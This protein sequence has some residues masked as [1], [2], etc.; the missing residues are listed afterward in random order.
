MQA[1]ARVQQADEDIGDLQNYISKIVIETLKRV[2]GTHELASGE[3]SY[4]DLGI[5]NQDIKQNAYR[6]QQQAPAT[7]RAPKEA[8]LDLIDFDKIIRQ[9]TNWPHFEPIFS[10]QMPDE[11][12]KKYYLAWLERLNE[13]RRVSAHKSPYRQY[14]DEDL[15]FVSFIK[16][17]L[18]ERFMKAGFDVA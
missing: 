13:I 6:K 17:Q 4:W 9:A 16:A 3:K 7:K 10:I 18:F 1:N 5:D 15:E 8:Y 2:H 14:S 11:R 12:G